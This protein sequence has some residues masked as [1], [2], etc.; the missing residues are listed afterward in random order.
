MGPK[1]R[2][3]GTLR[4]SIVEIRLAVIVYFSRRDKVTERVSVRTLDRV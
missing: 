4:Y 1:P 3:K 2:A